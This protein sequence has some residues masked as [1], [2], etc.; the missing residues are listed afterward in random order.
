[1]H[2]DEVGATEE[3]PVQW[4]C[5]LCLTDRKQHES[6][7]EDQNHQ[8]IG[9][10]CELT[11]LK[12]E[13]IVN[14]PASLCS[15]CKACLDEFESFRA[16]CLANDKTF[17]E[18]YVPIDTTNEIVEIFHVSDEAKGSIPEK[19]C[20]Y[21]CTDE[22]VVDGGIANEQNTMVVEIETQNCLNNET[23]EFE[24]YY[25][26]PSK[27]NELSTNQSAPEE[28][29]L[30]FTT[31][32]TPGKKFCTVCNKYVNRLAQHKLIHKEFRPFQCEYCS[33]GFN[34]M[35]NLKK[36]VRLHTKE[37]PYLCSECDK[38][39]T[40]STELKIHVRSHT[41]ERPFT[42]A[43]CGKSFVTSGH[44]VRHTRTHTGQKPYG[45]DIC[46]AKFSTSSHLVRH[47]RLHSMEHPYDCDTCGERFMRREHLKAHKCKP[48]KVQGKSKIQII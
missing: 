44:L 19:E 14:A 9:W 5:R 33:K 48:V 37:K 22:E 38:G 35:S 15:E 23:D 10:I 20:L 47:K 40:N 4:T 13:H 36:H 41:Q 16:M 6:L 24:I 1:M 26:N 31:G 7:F 21:T 17:Q 34:Q 30:K 28:K 45:C 8:M 12:I 25:L 18:K 43:D 3:R 32:V 29:D 39:F 46:K 42:C 11:S 2:T 27:E